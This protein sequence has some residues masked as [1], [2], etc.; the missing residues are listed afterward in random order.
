MNKTSPTPSRARSRSSASRRLLR[1]LLDGCYDQTEVTGEHPER[2]S[3]APPDRGAR[4]GADARRVFIGD[5]P[6]Q[7]DRRRSAPRSVAFAHDLAARGDRRH[8]DRGAGRHAQRA[9]RRRARRAKS[10]RC[11]PPPACRRS[12]I[13]IRPYRTSD[14]AR[15]RHACGSTIRA[16]RPRP[17][18][19]GC[20]R[21]ISARPP[22][23]MH[24]DEQAVLES[25]LRHPAQSRRHGRQ[26]GRPGAAARRNARATRRAAPPCST[27][28]ARAKP[29]RRN[30]PDANKGKISDVG[31]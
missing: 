24:C 16:W 17:A 14:P 26:S 6:R 8:R 18:R 7:P 22:T 9:R 27:S 19:A 2:L 30:Y 29:P 15:A 21:T 13:E 25:R 10:A 31:Q 28:T 3:P 4:E 5:Q 23:A 20:G 12:A 1:R 11:S